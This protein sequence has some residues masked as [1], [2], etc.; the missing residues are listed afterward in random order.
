MVSA[1]EWLSQPEPEQ[2]QEWV[3]SMTPLRRAAR[4]LKRINDEQVVMWESFVR[5]S[6]FPADHADGPGRAK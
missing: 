4:T 6:R 1:T 3:I 5:A 2:N